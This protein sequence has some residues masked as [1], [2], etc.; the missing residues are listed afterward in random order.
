M[1]KPPVFCL[2]QFSYPYFGPN[3]PA[4]SVKFDANETYVS[5]GSSFEVDKHPFES[6]SSMGLIV[7]YEKLMILCT[8]RPTLCKKPL[9]FNRMFSIKKVSI[10]Q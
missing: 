8:R 3:L 5:F 7:S 1:A 6:A 10:F 4:S 9:I 2:Q